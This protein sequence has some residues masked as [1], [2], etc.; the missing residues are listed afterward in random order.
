MK[1]KGLEKYYKKTFF[2]ISISIIIGLTVFG[3]FKIAFL[4]QLELKSIDYRF[5]ETSQLFKQNDNIV[6][7][8]IDDNS[9]KYFRNNGI[10][11]PWPRDFYAIL[12]D[13]IKNDG[14]KNILFDILFYEPDIER[15]ETDAEYTDG[16]FA[17]S[18]EKNK[19]VILAVKLLKNKK[20]IRLD[21]RFK[22]KIKGY[23]PKTVYRGAILPIQTFINK[24]HNIGVI[25]V[26]PDKDGV[27]R[28]VPLFY[29]LNDYFLP[30]MGVS[31]FIENANIK[32]EKK[33]FLINDKKIPVNPNAQYFVNWYK[34]NYFKYVT[35][36]SVI[37]SAF[38]KESKR[39]LPK[40]FFKD[41]IVLIG[42]T[43]TGIDDYITTPFSKP[44][45]GVELWATVISNIQDSYFVKQ[46]NS[47]LNFLF[48]IAVNFFTIF[49]FIRI[50]NK[51]GSI[52]FIIFPLLY[53]FLSFWIFGK[54]RLILPIVPVY[55]AFVLSFIYSSMISY[56]AEGKSKRELKKVFSRYLH[57]D[58]VEKIVENPDEIKLGGDSI[59]ATV[60]FSDIANFTTYSEGKSAEEVI[61]ILNKYFESFSEFI[62]DNK[63]LLDKYMGD[64]IMAIFGAP[65]HLKNHAYLACKTALQ[66]KK[67]AETV[68]NKAAFLHKNTR[69]GINSGNIVAGNLGSEKKT[70]YTAIGDDVNLGSRLEG[71]NKVYK[72]KIIISQSTYD[73]VKDDFICR[74]LDR[75]KVK[76]K[77]KATSIYELIDFKKDNGSVMWIDFYHKGLYEYKKGNWDEAIK[78]F[79]KVL[80]LKA[81]DYPSELMIERCNKL[82]IENPENWDG[83]IV[84]KSK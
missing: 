25:N 13:Y 73:L 48:L 76:G 68:T 31:S 45:P 1:R 81:N 80:E 53:I 65:F 26:V 51:K 9:L 50:N 82:K 5:R 21:D 40:G 67:F 60:F 64:G 15:E 18:I 49:I 79:N 55:S 70:D 72:T 8:S 17:E 63:G 20:N 37:Q 56:I 66:H 22:L 6:I 62:L 47:I 35:F 74:E 16:K 58:V 30:Q 57:P 83:V 7:V 24:V 61:T 41:K 27:I 2:I 4:E 34:P 14:A 84:L 33:Y 52:F 23:E 78:Y 71:V 10:S 39:L 28:H 44:I 75:L 54:Y 12:C 46:T 3:L 38:A 59:Y 36:S 19:N 69:I 32:Y 11:W 77:N 29:K 43:A 42:S